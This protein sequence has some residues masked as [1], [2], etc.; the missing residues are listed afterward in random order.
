MPKGDDAMTHRRPRGWASA[1]LMLLLAGGPT[2]AFAQQ[3]V[4]NENGANGKPAGLPAL[5]IS[6]WTAQGTAQVGSPFCPSAQL[7]A[8]GA[9]RAT[10]CS[11]TAFGMDIIDMS[12]AQLPVIWANI[13]AVANCDNVVKAPG[14][15]ILTDQI[16]GALNEFVCCAGFPCAGTTSLSDNK[17]FLGPSLPIIGVMGQFFPDTPMADGDP[18]HALGIFLRTEPPGPTD[19][20]F[21]DLQAL[22]LDLLLGSQSPDFTARFRVPFKMGE[23]G[24]PKH[25]ERGDYERGEKAFYLADDGQLIRVRHREFSLGFPTVRAEVTFIPR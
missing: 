12:G 3:M 9:S 8:A 16:G 10:S 7:A 14:C 17:Q 24:H 23:R 4:L 5:R 1:A 19:P 18:N 2:P 21:F 22:A 20:G 6:H 13:A 15:P 25:F 11:V